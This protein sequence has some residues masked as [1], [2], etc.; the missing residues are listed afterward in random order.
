VIAQ[1]ARHSLRASVKMDFPSFS[2]ALHN[3]LL[4][5]CLTLVERG[6]IRF[7]GIEMPP[8]HSKTEICSIQFP[9]WCLQRHPKWRIVLAS[10]AQQLAVL[11]SRRIRDYLRGSIRE[12]KGAEREWETIEGGG[13]RAV[14]IGSGLTGYGADLMIIDDPVKDAEE[15]RS[16]TTLDNHWDWYTTVARTR[17]QPGG[18]IVM[19]M[20]RWAVLDLAG[21]VQREGRS[22]P[23]ADQWYFLTLPALAGPDDPL[24][25]LEGDALWPAAYNRNDLLAVKAL[26]ADNFE[27]L[28]Q[29]NPRPDSDIKFNRSDL[30]LVDGF[31]LS[32]A[33][34]WVRSWDLAITEN[35][36]SD[37]MVGALVAAEKLPINEETQKI[38][39]DARLPMPYK[40][41]VDDI[42]RQRATWPK[43]RQKI[44]E[45]A[46]KDGAGIHIVIEKGRLDL[47]AVQQIKQDLDTLGFTVRTHTPKGDKIARKGPLQ[48]VA[49]N[50][51]LTFQSGDWNEECFREFEHFPTYP[52]D[53]FVDAVE[54]G[55]T[56][57]SK[58]EWEMS[59][60]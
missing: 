59:A 58:A 23:Q 36:S 54:Q 43:Q 57:L 30:R 10:Y 25:R 34:Q 39:L 45:T 24:G 21:R 41:H 56:V 4:M 16:I 9:K 52:H 47:A 37:Y 42:V 6:A 49:E 33:A 20:T 17:L 26:D 35:E 48:I 2:F 31:P 32:E 14:G 51:F 19:P 18:R 12:E 44:I 60:I 53:D 29:Q 50:G 11:N 13:V 8:R 28:Y 46:L 38:L 27:S 3:L 40:V 7:L 55:Y 5:D 22:N 1:L 15:A